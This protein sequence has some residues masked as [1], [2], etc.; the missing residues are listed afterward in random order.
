MMRRLMQTLLVAA[1]CFS[2][3]LLPA[4]GT[5]STDLPVLNDASSATVSLDAEYRLGRNWARILR[6]QAP[7]LDDPISYQYLE[8]L[9]WR[10]LP[11][12]QVQDRRL[13]LFLLDNPT[14]N[15]FAVPGGIIGIHSGLL[16]AA[17]TEGELASVIAHEL[18]HLSQ[19]HYAQRL[20]EERRNRPL[21]LAGLLASILVAAAD[22]QGGMAVLSSTMGANAQGQ[23]AFSRRNEQEAD[24]VG[25]QTLVEAG[26]DPHTMPQMFSRLQRNYRFYGQRPPEFLLTHPVTESRIADSLNRASQLPEVQSHADNSDFNLIRARMQVHHSESPQKAL[27]TFRAATQ[28]SDQLHNR[29]GL[30]LAAIAAADFALADKTWNTLDASARRHPWLL[31]S[32]VERFLAAADSASALEISRELIALYPDSRPVRT[33]HA[34]ALRETGQLQ[35]AIRIYKQLTRDYPTDTLI[36]FELAEA[37]GLAGNILAV[38]EA[39]IEYFLL[40]AQFDLALKQLE[41]AAREK[42]LTDSDRARLEQRE[43]EAKAL[44][45][46]MKEQF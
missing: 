35:Q 4:T 22:T 5:A 28:D 1:T 15:A 6:A 18:A 2:T 13:E 23:L 3:A 20:E 39:R 12:S 42:D 44:R 11:K 29:Y 38:H 27:A 10:L 36:W 31:L 24:R 37:E 46:E 17:E 14:F 21:M 40:T 43:Q 26:I 7:L 16:L 19:R 45:Q 8:D 32:R 33:L 30:M 25:M 41:Y 34:R 9:L